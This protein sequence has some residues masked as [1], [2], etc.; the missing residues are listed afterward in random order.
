MEIAEVN[1]NTN[2]AAHKNCSF[3]GQ[4]KTLKESPKGE[5]L[6]NFGA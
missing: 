2:Y 3:K 4:N 1:Y 5:S 6:Y